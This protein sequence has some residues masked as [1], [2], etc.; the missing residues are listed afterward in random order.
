MKEVIK[1]YG[2]IKE[3]ED[4]LDWVRTTKPSL[5]SVEDIKYFLNKPFKLYNIKTGE[6]DPNP[7]PVMDGI[8]WLEEHKG[9][10]NRNLVCWNEERGGN[11]VKECTS[12]N[13]SDIVEYFDEFREVDDFDEFREIGELHL[14]KFID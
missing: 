9:V 8:Y 2:I 10:S 14:W 5:K 12:Y 13:S 4:D 1:R 3:E 6:E 7:A 11:R